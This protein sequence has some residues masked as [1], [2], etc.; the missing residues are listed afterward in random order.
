[1]ALRTEDGR[2]G[3]LAGETVE[4]VGV[5]DDVRLGGS[6]WVLGF[7][8]LHAPPRVVGH[9]VERGHFFHDFIVERVDVLK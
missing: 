5:D 7:D 2:D 6:G 4:R 3:D 8:L 1:M 9:V